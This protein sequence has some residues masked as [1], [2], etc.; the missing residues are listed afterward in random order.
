MI[1]KILLTLAALLGVVIVTLATTISLRWDRKFE[2][3]YPELKASSD[4]QVIARGRYLA[5]GPAHCS[6]CHTAD[7]DRDLL[8]AGGTPPLSGGLTFVIPP[9]TIRVPNITPDSATGIGRR[10]DGE[11]ARML[12]YGV[13]HDGRAAFPFMEFHD[14]SDSDIVA[15]LS[16]VRSQ[17]P[18]AHAVADHELSWVGKGASAFLISPIG[19]SA[20]P[21]AASPE[22]GPTL[23]RGAYLV[24]ALANC[25]GCHSQRSMV[26]GAYTGP[27][28]QGGM[29]MESS[30]NAKIK[31]VPPD[32]TSRPGGRVAGWTEDEFVARFRGG[33]RIPGSPMPWQAFGRMS[34]DDLRAIYRYLRSVPIS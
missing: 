18:V 12:R 31:L 3:P 14:M 24:S 6:D 34:D 28:L 8:R 16:F 26:S 27:K 32:I 21:P 2:A 20:S 1:K 30:V 25:A 11:I 22:P 10:S 19:P 7:A 5:F 4:P 15:V 17:P 23:E 9:G 29:E 33:E 13:R